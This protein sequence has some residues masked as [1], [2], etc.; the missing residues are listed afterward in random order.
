MNHLLTSFHLSAHAFCQLSAVI[1]KL[2]QMEVGKPI[3]NLPSFSSSLRKE[4]YCR[5][6]LPPLPL[7]NI[8]VHPCVNIVLLERLRKV[9]S[10]A[11][12]APGGGRLHAQPLFGSLMVI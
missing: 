12:A 1:S 11:V 10:G 7:L 3:Y 8:E 2:N 4:P 6:L 9:A 5:E